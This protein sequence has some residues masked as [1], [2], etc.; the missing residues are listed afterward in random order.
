MSA[1]AIR[2]IGILYAE[3]SGRGLMHPFFAPI[4]NAIKEEAEANGFCIL[5]I[6]YKLITT[7]TDCAELCRGAGLEGVCLVCFDFS[8][9]EIRELAA[10]GIPC[11]TIDH[12]MKGVPTVISD[13]ENGVQRLIEYAISKGHRRI[14]FVHGHNN[15]VVTRTRIQL[16]RNTMDYYKLPVP[17]DYLREGEYDN[18]ELTRSI[19][20]ELLRLPERPTCILLPDDIAYI[21][22][23]DAAWE[24]GLRIPQDISFAGYDGLSI[25]QTLEPKLTTIRQDCERI[26]VTAIQTLIRQ[27][28]HPK[29]GRQ[30]PQ[31]LP[32]EFLAGGT[33]GPAAV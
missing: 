23:R 31:V 3:E 10:S 9:P 13:N 6:N 27:I 22:A 1:A 32:V 18:I 7:G 26:G 16:F 29:A 12:M 14:A 15:S 17:A 4:L 28:D 33:I 20:G 25:G 24:L 5:F 8:S 2:K 30:V 19:V 11:V 21:G